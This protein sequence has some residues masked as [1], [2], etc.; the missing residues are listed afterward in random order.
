MYVLQRAKHTVATAPD[1]D[2]IVVQSILCDALHEMVVRLKVRVSDMEIIQA[3]G[4][5]K[6]IPVPVCRQALVPLQEITGLKIGP[7]ITRQITSRVGGGEGCFHLTDLVMEATR[8]ALQT[9]HYLASEQLEEE[10]KE[11]YFRRELEGRCRANA[12]DQA[13]PAGVTGA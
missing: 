3:D 10:E 4:E 6:R 5:F 9:K 8:F 1:P 12:P 7:G 13:L 11:H 2:T